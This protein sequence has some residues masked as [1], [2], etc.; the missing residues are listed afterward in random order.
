[1][2]KS[3]RMKKFLVNCRKNNVKKFVHTNGDSTIKF[4][5]YRKNKSCR[6]LTNESINNRKRS[7]NYEK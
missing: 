7:I 5:F 3:N 6:H 2:T 1:M 4:S